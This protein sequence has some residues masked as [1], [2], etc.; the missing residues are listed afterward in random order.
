MSRPLRPSE[1]DRKAQMQ[2]ARERNLR[3]LA[4][5]LRRPQKPTKEDRL[6]AAAAALK[7][8]SIRFK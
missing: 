5:R 1:I 8:V 3:E 4:A 6:N 7:A 2:A